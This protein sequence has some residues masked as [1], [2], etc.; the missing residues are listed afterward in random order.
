MPTHRKMQTSCCCEDSNLVGWY[1]V[2]IV[3][4]TA[5]WRKRRSS[6]FRVKGPKSCLI[7]K[8]E[9]VHLFEMS[10]NIYQS[11]KSDISEDLDLSQFRSQNFN[12]QITLPRSLLQNV[13][14][15]YSESWSEVQIGD[16][17]A[18]V[19]ISI[20]CRLLIF[21]CFNYCGW[22]NLSLMHYSSSDDR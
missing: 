20:N 2:Q 22:V 4:V 8:I 9:A 11:T 5:V 1:F 15:L 16:M 3:N 10:A 19:W 17:Q 13:C 12:H 18:F 6:I 14:D 21:V 7:P